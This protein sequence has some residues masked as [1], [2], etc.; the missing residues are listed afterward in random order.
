MHAIPSNLSHRRTYLANH[1]LLACL[2]ML[3][4]LGLWGCMQ[5]PIARSD[6][7]PSWSGRIALQ[8]QG[9]ASQSFSASFEL[10]GSPRSGAMTLLNPLGIRL[11]Q[12][13][14]SAGHATLSH[15]QNTRTSDSLESLLTDITGTEIPV[16]ALFNWLQGT[17][18][19]AP[20][21]QADLT[22]IAH[23]RVTAYRDHPEPPATL[24]IILER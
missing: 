3:S 16:A 18:S 15:A 11:A 20:G 6:T 24:R 22:Q 7:Q 2:L 10:H 9:Q 1:V 17:Q 4:T 19:T 21:W 23:G 5:A 13:E 12:L 14:W 8:V